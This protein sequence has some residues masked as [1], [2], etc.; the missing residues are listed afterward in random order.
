MSPESDV[1]IHGEPICKYEF[2]YVVVKSAFWKNSGLVTS[3]EGTEL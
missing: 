2:S 1:A 3:M